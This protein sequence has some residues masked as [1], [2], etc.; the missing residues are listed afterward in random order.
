MM[1]MNKLKDIKVFVMKLSLVGS[2]MLI[3]TKIGDAIMVFKNNR[4][5]KM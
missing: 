5:N 3:L 2:I 1:M 4:I